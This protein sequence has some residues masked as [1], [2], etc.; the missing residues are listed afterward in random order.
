M[1][2]LFKTKK[3]LCLTHLK[4]YAKVINNL[5]GVAGRHRIRSEEFHRDTIANPID[6]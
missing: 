3:S 5:S 6:G 1:A 2:A 4:P